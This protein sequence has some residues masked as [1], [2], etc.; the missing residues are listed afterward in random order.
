[1]LVTLFFLFIALLIGT[2]IAWMLDN[3]GLVII[4]WLGYEV[5][6]DIL[7]TLLIFL[8]FI[9]L[10]FAITY[11]LARILAFRF[12]IFLKIFSKK[13]Q[14]KKLQEII[15]KYWLSSDISLQ[16]LAAIEIKDIKSANL[17]HQKFS[18]IFKSTDLNNFYLGKIAT[19]QKDFSS[20]EK[21]YSKIKENR[22]VKLLVIK[23]KLEQ[24]IATNDS[25]LAITYSK[26]ILELKNDDLET[27]R[28]LFSLYKQKGNWQETQDLLQKYDNKLFTKD[29]A[30]RDKVII[31]SALAANY[32]YKKDFNSAIKYSKL[33]L[34]INPI[35]L[36]SIEIQIKSYIKKGFSFKAAWLIK[37]LWPVCPHLILAELYDFLNHK[38]SAEKRIEKIKNLTAN[39]S[40]NYLSNLA[41]SLI[42]FKV[43]ELETAK[44]YLACSLSKEKTNRAYK[45]LAYSQKADALKKGLTNISQEQYKKYS[46][47]A[48][49][50]Q[51]SEYYVCHNCSYHNLKWSPKCPSCQTYDSMEWN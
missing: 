24:A 27:A 35:F 8:F 4:N 50:L 30:Q 20:A 19:L 11:L 40:N 34:K 22:L 23:S 21:Y 31:N 47:K 41:I 32:Y 49:L 15:K 5:R 16:T 10:T 25:I 7:T 1:M 42:A 51:K 3:N 13:T 38:L 45:L 37:N 12:P 9:L 18:K 33:A 29:L 26:Q 44:E 36:P 14:I 39:N 48:S 17:Y 28:L 6:A 43:G 2:L 46:E